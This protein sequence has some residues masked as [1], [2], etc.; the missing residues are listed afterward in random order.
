MRYGFI[1]I[2]VTILVFLFFQFFASCEKL[3][4]NMP[5]DPV[6]PPQFRISSL[7]AS[8]SAQFSKASLEKILST[9]NRKPL[10]VDLREESHG[11]INGNA[12]SWRDERNWSNRGK[13][14]KEIEK[15]EAMRLEKV[16]KQGFTFLH[17]KRGF[18]PNLIRVKE[19]YTEKSLASSLGLEYVRLPVTDHVRPSNLEVDSFVKLVIEKGDEWLHFHCSA[20]KGRSTTFLAMLDMMKNSRAMSFDEIIQRQVREGGIDLLSDPSDKK[21]KIETTRDR[22]KF[23]RE[24][25]AYCRA[26]DFSIP[27]SK[28]ISLDEK[29]RV[30]FVPPRSLSLFALS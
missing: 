27:F 4:L 14:L 22:E 2:L 20:G 15:E 23:L 24:F 3:T 26:Q 28:W 17:F 29:M 30:S 5:N 8:A 6:L 12:I 16:K 9:L 11:F 25:Y 1:A 13:A 21:W 18:F 10:I 19:A 7:G